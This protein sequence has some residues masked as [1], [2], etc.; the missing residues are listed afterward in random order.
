MVTTR[1]K[2]TIIFALSNRD[3]NNPL[4]PIVTATVTRETTGQFTIKNR[5]GVEMNLD[6]DC[7]GPLIRA[8]L[9]LKI[10][11]RAELARLKPE[12]N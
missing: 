6:A 4:S 8:L 11:D 12:Y 10:T 2:E 1:V 3:N 7:I 5:M 9:E